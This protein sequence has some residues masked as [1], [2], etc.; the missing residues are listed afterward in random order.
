MWENPLFGMSTS[1][2]ALAQQIL[3]GRLVEA[4]DQRA[5]LAQRGR[6]K[7]SGRPEQQAEQLGARGPV[8]LEIDVHDALALGDVELVHVLQ[9]RERSVALDGRLLRVR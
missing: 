9:H 4:D 8:L 1:L 3:V 5:L 6:S 2:S 7:I